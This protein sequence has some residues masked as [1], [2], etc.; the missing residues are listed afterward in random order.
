MN[1]KAVILAVVGAL[2]AMIAPAAASGP[3]ERDVVDLI[4]RSPDRYTAREVGTPVDL[5][6]LFGPYTIPPGQDSNRIT[7]DLPLNGGFLTAVAPDLVEVSTG[8]I[9][10]QQE[11]HIHHAHWF[12][13]TDDPDQEYYL[14]PGPAGLSWVFGTG[15]EK[16]Q[17]R[18]DDR[19]RL[20]QAAGNDWGYGIPLDGTTPQALIYMIH[21][22][23]SSVGNYFVVLDV[24]FIPG[25]REEIRAATGRDI[26]PLYGQLW[27]RTKDVTT[28]SPAIGA[29][30]QVTHDAVAVAAG[31]HLH[32]GGKATI[33]TN[34]GRF[35]PV[36]RKTACELAEEQSPG[37]G[38]P[39]GDGYLGVTILNS[40]KYDR[41]ME[42]WPYTENYQM[43][44][45]KFGWRAPLHAGDVL[46][47]HGLYAVHGDGDGL[48][49][50]R[51]SIDG[52]D[53]N[54]YEA[55]TH[56]GIYMDREYEGL[57]TP[58]GVCSM[59]ALAPRMLGD[60]TFEQ[61]AVSGTWLDDTGAVDPHLAAEV[62]EVAEDWNRWLPASPT[63]H[64]RIT[65]GMVNHLWH[66][67]P[68]PLCAQEGMPG[69]ADYP[70]C[71]PEDIAT[72]P[73][74][75]VDTIHTAG[76]LYVPGDLSVQ[77]GGAPLVPQVER[78]TALTF[79]NEDVAGN[80]R[81]T[82]TSCAWPCFGNYVSN[83]PLPTG[84]PGAFDTGKMGNLDPI[85]GGLTGDDTLPLYTLDTSDMDPGKYAYFC[86][87][88]P[89]MR[90]AFEIIEGTAGGA[91]ASH[92][93]SA[94]QRMAVRPV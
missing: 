94:V 35:D 58:A 13:V 57:S 41:V 34:L 38:D 74:P 72:A 31:S 67:D 33:V 11:A 3:S 29:D 70:A 84:G 89:F 65:H 36:T 46:R 73:G 12:R 92:L 45:T 83:F 21:N 90:G 53:H 66:G 37:A 25:T 9:P 59:E 61:Q 69:L 15:E 16:T 32:P 77:V 51:G 62:A 52:L 24:T 20:E 6:L 18:L 19:A 22:K 26:H 76:F 49:G 91:A 4:L 71:G 63:M 80:I 39:D 56:T 40:Y 2:V 5:S 1:R 43:G 48:L 79:V 17:G 42:A 88:H 81:H 23:T 47:Q 93:W 68:E 82:F 44:A 60:D 55:M 54:W 75:T 8:R 85:D 30:W 7:L 14:N 50:G 87:V 64:Q 10:T 86:R 28:D 78:G 27:G